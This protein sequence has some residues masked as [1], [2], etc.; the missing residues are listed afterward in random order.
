[1]TTNSLPVLATI[2]ILAEA[3]GHHQRD[4]IEKLQQRLGVA[5]VSVETFA[6]IERRAKEHREACETIVNNIESS[7]AGYGV[8][9]V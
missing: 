5:R 8:T 9:G 7:L 6:A 1:M 4:E 2:P 3:P